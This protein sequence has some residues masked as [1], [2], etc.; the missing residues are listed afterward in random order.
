[1][2]AE[3]WDANIILL[4]NVEKQFYMEIFPYLFL[5][6]G[7]VAIAKL[8]KHFSGFNQEKVGRGYQ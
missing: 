1:M 6:T 2:V 4:N 5:E 8:R 7:Q 3:K